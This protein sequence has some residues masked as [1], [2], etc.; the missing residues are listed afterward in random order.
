VVENT[1]PSAASWSML[2]V[3][4]QA[5]AITRPREAQMEAVANH[6]RSR[7]MASIVIRPGHWLCRRPSAG[8]SRS[9]VNVRSELQSFLPLPT[10]F[11]LSDDGDECYPNIPERGGCS[12]NFHL[13]QSFGAPK[14]RFNLGA[15]RGSWPAMWHELNGWGGE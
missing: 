1:T 10:S 5:L 8:R 15:E 7:F 11:C 9:P 6:K 2:G 14:S 12:A 13:L 4:I 3:S